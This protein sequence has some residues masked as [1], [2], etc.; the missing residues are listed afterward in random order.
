[1]IH[2]FPE[3]CGSVVPLRFATGAPR[4]QETIG[5]FQGA[6][7]IAWNQFQFREDRERLQRACF[8]QERVPR[9][10]QELE[11]LHD[12]FDLTNA[13]RAQLDVSP[14]VFVTNDVPLDPSFDRGNFVEQIRRRASSDK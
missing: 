1:M 2:R 12:K 9:S 6:G 7:F 14:D 11:R 3:S 8:L 4:A 13:A 5:R 10:M